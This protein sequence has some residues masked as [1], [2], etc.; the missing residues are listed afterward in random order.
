MLFLEMG[1]G[2]EAIETEGLCNPGDGLRY[3]DLY[4][5]YLTGWTPEQVRELGVAD[6]AMIPVVYGALVRRQLGSR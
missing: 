2:W 5:C 4:L 6:A 3:E 1:M